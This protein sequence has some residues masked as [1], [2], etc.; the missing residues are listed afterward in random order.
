MGGARAYPG[1]PQRRDAHPGAV[2]GWSQGL[3]SV[4]VM[5]SLGSVSSSAKEHREA[6]E[7]LGHCF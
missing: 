2:T 6:L 1:L 7:A 5:H 3:C 4:W